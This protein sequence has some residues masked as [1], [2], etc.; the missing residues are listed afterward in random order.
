MFY[1]SLM[2]VCPFSKDYPRKLLECDTRLR[3]NT[4]FLPLRL[5]R[6]CHFFLYCQV[7]HC[8][9]WCCSH[10][11]SGYKKNHS[12]SFLK[13]IAALSIQWIIMN[14]NC[15]V[16]FLL[17]LL[18]FSPQENNWLH[19]LQYGQFQLTNKGGKI[20]SAK[21]TVYFIFLFSPLLTVTLRQNAASMLFLTQH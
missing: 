18:Q 17:P 4:M 2:N 19:H 21:K 9:F 11:V 10:S 13:I 16:I 20:I 8:T 6:M 15:L 12:F 1:F 3:V 7:H 5:R 14:S